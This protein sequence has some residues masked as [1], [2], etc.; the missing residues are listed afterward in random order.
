MPVESQSEG[1]QSTYTLS[2]ILYFPDIFYVMKSYSPPI[3]DLVYKYTF[4]FIIQNT[5]LCVKKRMSPV[6]INI[7]S[8]ILYNEIIIII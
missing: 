5:S 2:V 3:Y 1:P 6:T 4:L 7:T 8:D